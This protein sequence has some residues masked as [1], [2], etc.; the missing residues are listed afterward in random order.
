M[1]LEGKLPTKAQMALFKDEIISDTDE[2]QGGVETNAY[3]L[4]MVQYK[5]TNPELIKAKAKHK[6]CLDQIP[7]LQGTYENE[8][9]PKRKKKAQERLKRHKNII[10]GAEKWINTEEGPTGDSSLDA[11]L[12]QKD[13]YVALFNGERPPVV[14]SNAHLNIMFF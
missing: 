3:C 7:A 13:A 4:K 12:D 8:P 10:R 14:G 6:R 9:D 2:N 1:E 11:L 5:N